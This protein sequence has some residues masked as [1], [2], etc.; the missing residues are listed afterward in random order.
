MVRIA[1]CDDEAGARTELELG[2]V[3]AFGARKVPHRIDAMPSGGDLRGRMEAGARYDLIFLDIEFGDGEID[4]VEAGRTVREDFRDD[5]AHIVYVS[6]HPRHSLRLHSIRVMDFLI[7]P[8]TSKAIE[9][10]AGEYL[11]LAGLAAGTFA[12]R[13]GREEFEARVKDIAYLESRKRRIIVHFADGRTDEYYGTLKDAYEGQLR[14]RDFLFIH[15]SYLVN[16]AHAASVE[17]DDVWVEGLEKPL[18]ISQKRRAEIRKRHYE[19]VRR[20]GELG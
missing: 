5:A 19:I 16:H 2:V 20:M 7:K 9:R 3:A 1:I 6:W 11:R 14:E 8:L 4:G 17:Y 12:Y 15:A 18:P 10:A 13:K